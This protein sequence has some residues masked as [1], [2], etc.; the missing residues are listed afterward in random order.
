ATQCMSVDL[1]EPDGPMM[2]VNRPAS[3]PT[4]T[5]SSAITAVGPDPYTLAASTARAARRVRTS[6]D[7]AVGVVVMPRASARHPGPS[8][9]GGMIPAYARRGTR[10]GGGCSAAAVGPGRPAGAHEPRLVGEHDELGAVAGPQLGH[11][12]ADVGLG[13][14]GAD[15][16]P[17]GDLVVGQP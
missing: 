9:P 8:L 7:V 14:H 5:A 3:K 6:V 2:A 16:E 4:V 13:G 17:L 1:P 10:P 15:D 11:G 12:P